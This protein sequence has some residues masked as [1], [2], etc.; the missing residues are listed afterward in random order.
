PPYLLDQA[1]SRQQAPLPEE[2]ELQELELLR[3]QLEGPTSN[4]GLVVV[5]ID[6]DR[7][8]GEAAL[9]RRLRRRGNR[10]TPE[11]GPDARHELPHRERLGH[12]VVGAQLQASH[13]VGLGVLGSQHDDGD[14]LLRQDT[15]AT[16]ER[17][18]SALQQTKSSE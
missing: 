10:R 4:G 7:A 5:G 13:L 18:S 6:L 8:A 2:K 1:L 11:L 17:V 9:G 16:V 3:S 15:P 12:V 14:G